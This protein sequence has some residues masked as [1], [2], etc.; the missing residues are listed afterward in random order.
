[1]VLL[2][3]IKH[4]AGCFCNVGGCQ[5]ALE[6]THNDMEYH[7]AIGRVCSDSGHDIVNGKHTGT[8]IIAFD[9]HGSRLHLLER[10]T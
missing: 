5:E 4:C 6:L 3:K 8:P 1:M 2:C 7:Y 10:Q 9:L